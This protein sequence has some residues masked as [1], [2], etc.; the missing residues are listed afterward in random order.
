[1]KRQTLTG[2]FIAGVILLGLNACRDANEESE[3][4]GQ[5][6]TRTAADRPARDFGRLS[7]EDN[8]LTITRVSCHLSHGAWT[9]R[10]YG[11]GFSFSVVF[12]GQDDRSE[13][14]LKFEG[15]QRDVRF[16]LD[17]ADGDNWRFTMNDNGGD[18]MGEIEAST[19]AISGETHMVAANAY[20]ARSYPYPEGV[21]VSFDFRCH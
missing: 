10:A 8:E 15:V 4:S 18:M 14:N 12:H 11:D 17:R 2:C 5:S 6:E 16:N 19:E 9:M 1:M 13:D 20:A 21:T 7:W 3:V